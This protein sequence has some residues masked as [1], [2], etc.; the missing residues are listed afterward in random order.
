[1]KLFRR[2]NEIS[3]NRI[4]HTVTVN[5]NGE[6]IKLV[7][8]ADPMRLIAGLNKAQ[9]KLKESVFKEDPTEEEVK[10]AAEFFSAVLFGKEQTAKL[11]EFY[12]NDGACV[13]NVCGQ[14]FKDQ[15]TDK[16]TAMQKK[17]KV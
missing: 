7:V 17:M 13:I 16:I 6:K 4:H 2:K 10:E 8:N 12:A 5:E 9:A 15:L 14:I 3:L 1:M 11:M